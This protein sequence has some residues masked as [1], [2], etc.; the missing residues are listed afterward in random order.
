[1]FVLYYG[2]APLAAYGVRA[3]P[4]GTLPPPPYLAVSATLLIMA[5]EVP[6][7]RHL[8]DHCEPVG[9]AGRSIWIYAITEEVLTGLVQAAAGPPATP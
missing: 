6:L 2:T 7:V 5:Q 3:Q 4:W 9:Y 8:R 1:M